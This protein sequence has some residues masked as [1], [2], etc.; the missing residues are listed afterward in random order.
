LDTFVKKRLIKLEGQQTG[1]KFHDPLPKVKPS[2]FSSLFRVPKQQTVKERAIKAD[3]NIL[4]RLVT[5][6]EYGRQINLKQV[7]QHELMPVALALAEMNSLRSGDKS[8]LAEV[9]TSGV[10]CPPDIPPADDSCL[11]IDGQALLIALGKPH[12]AVTFGDF[13]DAFVKS[14]LHSGRN[15]ARID[16]T[17]D[18]YYPTSI[19]GNTRV[20]HSKGAR[21]VR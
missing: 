12:G 15:C 19:K 14:V 16:V 7:L 17:F 1:L 8:T 10:E 21:P 9:L 11:I 6:H 4:Q 3:R 2:T 18:R 20:K 13:A 5:A